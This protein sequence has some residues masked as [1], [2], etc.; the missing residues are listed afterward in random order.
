MKS[1][2]KHVLVYVVS[3]CS[4][5]TAPPSG[6]FDAIYIAKQEGHA[7]SLPLALVRQHDPRI[8]LNLV[9]MFATKF[10]L[11]DNVH[12]KDSVGSARADMTT[13]F[14]PHRELIQAACK[15]ANIPFKWIIGSAER[16]WAIDELRISL[17]KV[18]Q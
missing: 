13:A 12:P 10:D 5:P 1:R 11:L 15:E 7:S 18:L 2:T 16:N 6:P 3:P 8:R 17:G 9:I 4:L 14:K